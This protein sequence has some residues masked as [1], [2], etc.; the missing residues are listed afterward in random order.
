MDCQLMGQDFWG[1][2]LNR[3]QLCWKGACDGRDYLDRIGL[4]GVE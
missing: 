2:D 3:E 4:K 1:F